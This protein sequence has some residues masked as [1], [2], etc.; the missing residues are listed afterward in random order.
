M[1]REELYLRD[2]IEAADH[3][4]GFV[5]H[6]GAAGLSESEM[7]RS[8]ILQKLTVIGEAA[9]KVSEDLRSRYPAVPWRKIVA[10]RNVVVHGYFGIDW[11]IV[12]HAATIEVPRLREEVAAILRAEFGE[13]PEA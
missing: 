4:S 3:L 9:S 12:W 11:D 10:F 2:I 8:S 6:A 7:V 13:R 5:S 1:R